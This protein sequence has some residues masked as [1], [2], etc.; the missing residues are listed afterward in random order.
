MSE[1]RSRLH[2]IG[3]FRSADGALQLLPQPVAESFLGL[4]LRGVF[5]A[6]QPVGAARGGAFGEGG[7]HL[8][9]L[10]CINRKR[11]PGQKHP[12]AGDCRIQ[13]QRTV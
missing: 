12:V 3:S 8:A 4:C 6:D 2:H 10:H 5:T 11:F 13:A 9:G 7:N 1:K